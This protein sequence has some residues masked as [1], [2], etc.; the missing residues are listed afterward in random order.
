MVELISEATDV[1]RGQ[2]A[3]KN[4]MPLFDLLN[5][6]IPWH[7]KIEKPENVAIEA[8]PQVKSS[9]SLAGVDLDN[10]FGEG[11][12]EV[13]PVVSKERLPMKNADHA[14]ENIT[15]QVQGDLSFFENAQLSTTS[16]KA[17]ENEN[18]SSQSSRAAT[19]QSGS[20]G[21]ANKDSRSVDLFSG[22]Q[23]D[24]SMH[25]DAV[26][27]PGS[28]NSGGTVPSSNSNSDDLFRDNRRS[29]SSFIGPTNSSS[30]NDDD[31]FQDD[32][33]QSGNDNLN[34]SV[35]VDKNDDSLDAWDDFMSSTGQ[36]NHPTASF[37]EEPI[38]MN[39]FSPADDAQ[40]INYGAF[41]Q[42]DLF[43]AALNSQNNQENVNEVHSEASTLDR[44]EISLD[45]SNLFIIILFPF[46]E[47]NLKNIIYV[48]LSVCSG[49][50][51][52][53]QMKKTGTN[54]KLPKVKMRPKPTQH[55]L[56]LMWRR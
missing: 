28:T 14:S 20:S 34:Q 32:Q 33:W 43:S 24:I 5:L 39:L 29:T 51:M 30:V 49:I 50:S 10:F 54:L 21:S 1:N 27:G 17:K 13:T 7:S 40:K 35:I 23:A 53:V 55:V 56:V 12:G 15:F 22:S 9:V 19:F 16:V 8:A 36:K 52:P 42:P 44:F 46:L 45:T 31:W 4:E 48:C 41:Q 37:K 38:G 26:F 2:S 25:I 47:L 6:E 11:K 3:P 18:D